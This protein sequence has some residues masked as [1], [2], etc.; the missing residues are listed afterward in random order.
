MKENFIIR[1]YDMHSETPLDLEK[2]LVE[3]HLE[4][5]PPNTEE[6]LKEYGGDWFT[7]YVLQH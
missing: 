6:L 4:E 7:V 2:P 3:L 5:L 1:I